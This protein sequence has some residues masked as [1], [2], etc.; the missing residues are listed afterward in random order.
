MSNTGVVD[1]LTATER[2]QV[3]RNR[4]GLLW[5]W[6][7]DEHAWQFYSHGEQCWI[8]AQAQMGPANDF[9]PFTQVAL[10]ATDPI[11]DL[12]NWQMSNPPSPSPVTTTCG[13]CGTSWT[14]EVAQ[15]PN[16]CA[17]EST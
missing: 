4:N 16:G 8:G 13:V 15:C 3:W 11:D 5:R 7:M 6:S 1:R 14:A 10:P 12:V 9:G 2:D 17:W